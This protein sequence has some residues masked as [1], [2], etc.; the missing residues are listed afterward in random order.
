VVATDDQRTLELGGRTAAQRPWNA[1]S[2]ARAVPPPGARIGDGLRVVRVLGEG[3]MGVVLLTRDERLER[4]VAVKLIRP[5]QLQRFAAFPGERADAAE[6]GL[7]RRFVGEAR[8]MARV[9]HPN[10]VAVYSS[11]DLDGWPYIA[12]EYVPGTDLRTELEARQRR[13]ELPLAVD[14]AL[15]LIEQVCRGVQAIHDAGAVHRDLKPGNVL[16]GPGLRA[17]VCDLGLARPHGRV[18]QG[19]P[20]VVGTPAY[21]APEVAT[22]TA[23]PPELEG[24]ADVYALGVIAFELLAG[25]PPFVGRTAA[26]LLTQ[27]VYDAPPRASALRPELDPAYDD[28][29]ARALAKDPRARLASPLE[30]RDA[31]LRARERSLARATT[32]LHIAVVDDD[33]PCRHATTAL[34]AETLPHA[35]VTAYG[36]GRALLAALDRGAPRRSSPSRGSAAPASGPCCARSAPTRSW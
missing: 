21:L 5:E 18:E 13:G 27:Q 9:R 20:A 35:R 30:L 7:F 34:L 31:L 29:L 15:G 32:P 16:L 11:G 6:S 26:E 8:A 25:R 3:G 2:G 12:M 4:D 14:E 19:E 33:G 10:V 1:G 36:D 24:R 17:A 23:V 22:A 28:V